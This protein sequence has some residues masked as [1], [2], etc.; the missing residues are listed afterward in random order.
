MTTPQTNE[1]TRVVVLLAA[2]GCVALHRED[3]LREVSHDAAA[4]VVLADKTGQHTDDVRV[5]ATDD[6]GRPYFLVELL[7]DAPQPAREHASDSVRLM[8]LRVS[9]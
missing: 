9:R 6:T 8:S 4:W 1:G 3:W 2:E 5:L 7:P